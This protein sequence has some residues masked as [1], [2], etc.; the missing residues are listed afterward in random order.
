M[1]IL[2]ALLLGVLFF[3]VVG[4]QAAVRADSLPIHRILINEF[5]SSQ[6]LCDLLAILSL[7][8]SRTRKVLEHGI[9]LAFGGALGICGIGLAFHLGIP[10]A[11]VLTGLALLAL[12]PMADWKFPIRPIAFEL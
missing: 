1:Y 8:T 9:K 11:W 10:Y 3:V 6:T 7:I 4:I 2:G 12:R 5:D